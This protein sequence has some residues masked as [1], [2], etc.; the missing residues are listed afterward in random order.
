M[1]PQMILCFG[2][3]N[4]EWDNS[5]LQ[6][7]LRFDNRKIVSIVERWEKKVILKQL[8]NLDS[9]NASLGYKMDLADDLI[10][11]LNLASGF[12]APNLAELTSN[13]S[14]RNKPLRN[15]K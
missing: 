2:T 13:S 4:Y 7:G 9:F 11:R 1:L 6:A 14:R 15:W 12:R 5:V 8:I 3:I 10:V